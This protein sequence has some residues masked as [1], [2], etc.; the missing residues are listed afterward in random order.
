MILISSRSDFFTSLLDPVLDFVCLLWSLE[1]LYIAPAL[2]IADAICDLVSTG[3]TLRSN[4]LKEVQTI[5]ESQSVLVQTSKEFSQKKRSIILRLE[6]RLK[7]VMRAAKTKYIMMNAPHNALNKIKEIMPGLEEPSVIPLGANGEK[8]AIHA[9]AHET[10]FWA[11]MEKLKEVG[12]S[13]ILVVP[14]EKIFG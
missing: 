8:V 6:Q 12:A 3:S 9:V 10:D 7:G 11:T 1:M 13:S 5:L 14:I 2:Q 4:G